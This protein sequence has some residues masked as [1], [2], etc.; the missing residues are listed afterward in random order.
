MRFWGRQLEFDPSDDQ[1]GGET[2]RKVG[3][4]RS[5]LSLDDLLPFLC[6]PVSKSALETDGETLRS[7][8]ASYPVLAGSPL[9]FP[10]DLAEVEKVLQSAHTLV[11]LPRLTPI[12]QY[13]AYGLLKACGNNNNLDAEDAWYARH[14]WRSR[15][16]L[17]P[18]RGT[19]LDIGC[20]DALISRGMLDESVRYV[21]LDPS[22]SASPVVR[23]GG[24]GE[25][26]PFKDESFDAVGF[27]TSLDHVF[28][29]HLALQ[30][31]R[32]VLRPGGMLCLGTLLWTH[33]AQLHPD[34]VH[35][36]HFR[37]YEIEGA[38]AGHFELVDLKAYRWKN[39]DHRFGVYLRAIRK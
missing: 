9:L 15:R 30:E 39:A 5:F 36:H 6:D 32:R 37:P 10:C 17:E 35:F 26:L 13:C 12:Q 16:M 18:V 14:L 29:Y 23:V 3:R 33:D 1:L 24:L 34:T 21:G 31:A 19:F 11:E 2:L 28:D 27:V 22:R 7:G 38:L 4:T 8:D 25:F 20:D